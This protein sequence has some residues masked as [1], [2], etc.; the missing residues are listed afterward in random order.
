MIIN[1]FEHQNN[2]LMERNKKL[3]E[4]YITLIQTRDRILNDIKDQRQW[5]TEVYNNKVIVWKELDTLE[6]I[7][8]TTTKVVE[9]QRI[10]FYKLTDKQ[11][12]N[13]LDL[14]N[15]I[16]SKLNELK[17]YDKKEIL[18]IDSINKDYKLTIQKQWKK[19]NEVKNKI[20]EIKKEKEEFEKYKKEIEIKLEKEIEDNKITRINL[21][22]EIKKLNLK[23]K[24]LKKL[25]LE[26]NK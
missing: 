19:L 21:N 25:N 8:S 14:S 23:E 9:K 12:N 20:A 16:N 26:L 6:S 11:K 10:D 18:D 1:S 17:E 2:N 5:N 13:I 4:E 3:R 15:K 7:L 24:R 22:K